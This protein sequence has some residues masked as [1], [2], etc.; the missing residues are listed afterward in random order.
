ME[1]KRIRFA[2]RRARAT[3]FEA[4]AI[5]VAG[6][7][8]FGATYGA[9]HFAESAFWVVAMIGFAFF[10]TILSLAWVL[11]FIWRFFKFF[12]KYPKYLK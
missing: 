8:L 4:C 5:F 3:L 10:G 2:W 12:R 6:F 11:M 9:C 7:L 1:K